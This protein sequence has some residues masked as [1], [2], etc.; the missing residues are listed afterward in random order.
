VR[1]RKK[2]EPRQK[3]LRSGPQSSEQECLKGHAKMLQP[4][5]REDPIPSMKLPASLGKPARGRRWPNHGT[6]FGF[7]TR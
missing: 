3:R 4:N 2:Y 1:R 6:P 5:K 7:A